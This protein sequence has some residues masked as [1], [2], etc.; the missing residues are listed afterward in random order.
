[1]PLVFMMMSPHFPLYDEMSWIVAFALV[2]VGFGAAKWLF[3]K[4]ATPV[5]AQI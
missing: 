5:T 2:L 4:S 1:V 3:L